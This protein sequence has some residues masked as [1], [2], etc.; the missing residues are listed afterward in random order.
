MFFVVF[1]EETIRSLHEEVPPLQYIWVALGVF[2]NSYL[3]DESYQQKKR[4]QINLQKFFQRKQS[5]GVDVT[6][7]VFI[8]LDDDVSYKRLYSPIYKFIWEVSPWITKI[9]ITLS[10]KGREL[11][12]DRITK[13]WNNG[14]REYEVSLSN[15]MMFSGENT[16]LIEAEDISW[17]V[18]T[19]KII[20]NVDFKRIEV[21]ESVLYI[22]PQF[23]PEGWDEDIMWTTVDLKQQEVTYITYWCDEGSPE[24]PLL[25][26]H[27]FQFRKIP[28]C[29]T[30][31]LVENYFIWFES[32]GKQ[33]DEY[34]FSV[35]SPA[36]GLLIDAFP[37]YRQ[38][39]WSIYYT[40][41]FWE[42]DFNRIS[43]LYAQWD[44]EQYVL[45]IE[46]INL[47]TKQKELEI[48]LTD[49][50]QLVVQND[51]QKMHIYLYKEWDRK[52]AL[53]FPWNRYVYRLKSISDKWTVVN[54]WSLYS[55]PLAVYAPRKDNGSTFTFRI[56]LDWNMLYVDDSIK[57]T[58]FDVT[59]MGTTLSV[60]DRPQTINDPSQCYKLRTAIHQNIIGDAPLKRSSYDYPIIVWEW[61]DYSSVR[62]FH[63]GKSTW[64]E[65]DQLY[66]W[67]LYYRLW[68]ERWNLVPWENIYTIK[69]YDQ[70]GNQV[71]TEKVH[72]DVQ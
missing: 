46:R 45:R 39:L 56:T 71:C 21:G 25:L 15:E 19:K 49:G 63:N 1:N 23:I 51:R 30:F 31:S 9:T 55:L 14:K 57:I 7:T 28:A 12:K 68:K 29:A 48:V 41:I 42:R 20:L 32:L 60:V 66:K 53:S 27:A 11:V 72:L 13:P 38:Y 6:G 65:P 33:W 2:D 36:Q 47:S 35:N 4:M 50:N 69:S 37:L 22:D 61:W 59:A 52:K 5:K 16:Y 17:T 67:Y 24:A 62:I 44:E 70:R 40:L 43:T 3:Q 64:S 58:Q 26:E 8:T 34:L 18:V 54:Q 10:H